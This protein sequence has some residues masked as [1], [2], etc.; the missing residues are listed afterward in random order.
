MDRTSRFRNLFKRLSYFLPSRA[1]LDFRAKSFRKIVIAV[2]IFLLGMIL[3]LG[4]MSAR[5]VREVVVEDFNTQQLVLARHAAIQIENNLKSLK[6]ELSL[7]SL[8]PGMQY[9]EAVFVGKRME[10]AFS[11]IKEEGGI[12][13]R[14]VDNMHLMTHVVNRDGYQIQHTSPEEEK[15]IRSAELKD[16]R[17]V[18][19]ISDILQRAEEGYDN[20]LFIQMALPVRQVSVDE[21]HPVPT[22]RFSGVLLFIVDTTWLAEKIT[23]G[24][25]SGKTGYAWVIDQQG[26]FIYHPQ[27]EFIGKNA[28][29]ARKEKQPTI[30]FARINEIQKEKM[31]A[32]QDGM[33]W[34]ISGWHRGIK[35]EMKKLIAYAPIHLYVEEE[36]PIWSVAVVAPVS[37]VQGAIHEIQVRQ[38][39]LEGVVVLALLASSLLM[40]GIMFRW[41]IILKKEVEEKTKDLKKS[42]GQC[43]SLVEHADDII[44]TMDSK[45]HILS[46]NRYGYHLFRKKPEEI[47]G[48]NL[49]ELFS[50]EAGQQQMRVVREVFQSGISRQVTCAVMA[51]G[52]EHWL[53]IKY[54]GLLDDK[55]NSFAVLGIARD[56]TEKKKMEDQMFYTEKLASIGTLAAGVAHEIN[57]PLAVI[58]GFADLLLEKTQPDSESYEIL[59]TIER[60]GTNAKRVVENL[61]SFTRFAERK[62]EEVDINKNIKTVL[63]VVGNT[64]WLNKIVLQEKFPDSLPLVK[65]DSS[66]MQQVFFNVINN[67]MAAMK[68]GG[69]LGISTAAVED[70]SK[71]EIRISDTGPGIEKDHRTRIFDPL[72]T[73]KKVGE[74]TGLGLF[75]SY[76]IITKHEGTITFETRTQ[77]E[78]TETG[79]TF[80]IVLPAINT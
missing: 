67:A 69:V 27:M 31:L 24:I 63:A 49:I 79:T 25:R 65:G 74:G 77:D 56:I 28:F 4:W 35:G 78:S 39:M 29:E 21:A 36:K 40:L 62:E 52:N 50:A 33:S 72:F 51:D 70:G 30:S 73:T 75:V 10:I 19:R 44:F 58:L 76:G 71:V 8:S 3:L 41:S 64:L 2:T 26:T 42:E 22:G 60:Q 12:E 38:F 6:R 80:T 34:Y 53:S 57:N 20:K 66:E 46:M 5:K 68:G 17:S 43:R 45:A 54:S 23:K 32:G 61:L 55:G 18:I 9:V 48:G 37:E 11:R 13:I 15:Y 59:K 14:Y 47:L 16:T 1:G 7:L